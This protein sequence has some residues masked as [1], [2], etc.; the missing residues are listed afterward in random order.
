MSRAGWLSFSLAAYVL[1][2]GSASVLAQ[3]TFFLKPY[4]LENRPFNG[5]VDF[6]W[7]EK[8]DK[9]KDLKGVPKTT[10]SRVYYY[11]GEVG[12]KKVVALIDSGRTRNLYID[13]DGDNDLSNEEP[14]TSK[15]VRSV[16]QFGWS[17]VHRFGPMT[18]SS[19]A[20]DQ[21]ETAPTE[22][23]DTAANPTDAADEGEDDSVAHLP[24]GSMFVEQLDLDY[25]LV[26]PSMCRRGTIRLADKPYAIALADGN[27]NGRYGDPYELP[28]VRNRRPWPQQNMVSDMLAIDL[29]GNRQIDDDEYGLSEIQ[30]L[31]GLVQVEGTYYSVE[32]APDGLSITLE[33]AKPPLGTLAIVAKDA[34]VIVRSSLGVFRATVKDG[35]CVL[36]AGTYHMQEVLLRGQDER[37]INWRLRGKP[38]ARKPCEFTVEAD[39]VADLKIGPPLKAGT[40]QRVHRKLLS[41]RVVTFGISCTDPA[42]IEYQPGAERGKLRG[43]PPGVKIIG[44]SG[45]VLSVGK[46]EYG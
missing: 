18:F 11:K 24:P 13:L 5:P 27:Y 28:L 9:P 35:R 12:G 46:F 41:G 1:L 38:S 16:Y 36:P 23:T 26:R 37:K 33:V 25:L 7:L 4:S 22:P 6:C 29:N 21:A 15:R 31:T 34:E 42:G 32:V 40:T 10:G 43:L 17:S 14:W 39:K 30:P 2:S 45:N 8:C 3:G 19:T 20:V 44:E